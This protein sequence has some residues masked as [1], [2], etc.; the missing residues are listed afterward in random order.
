MRVGLDIETASEIGERPPQLLRLAP[1]ILRT[2]SIPV[3]PFRADERDE[4]IRFEVGGRRHT[5]SRA[6]STVPQR[7]RPD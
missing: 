4:R 1:P 6:C 2:Q 7:T 5:A 3:C